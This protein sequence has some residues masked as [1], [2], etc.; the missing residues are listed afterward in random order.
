MA[1]SPK[2]V[3][4]SVVMLLFLQNDC[5]ICVWVFEVVRRICT[6]NSPEISFRVRYTELLKPRTNLY[7]AVAPQKTTYYVEVL[8]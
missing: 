3:G 5:V 7:P 1:P 6:F 4:M 2:N 8:V